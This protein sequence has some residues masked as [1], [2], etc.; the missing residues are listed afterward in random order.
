ML[1]IASDQPTLLPWAGF[2]QKALSVDILIYSIGV[3]VSYGAKDHYHNRVKLA[4]SW[5]TLP[6]QGPT[7][8][9]PFKDVRF[10]PAGLVKIGKSLRTVFGK[11]FPHRDRA[12][13]IIDL[14]EGWKGENLLADLNE[15][16]IREMKRQLGVVSYYTTRDE[17]IP[18]Q[19]QSKTERLI[20]RIRRVTEGK[21]EY[22]M[23]RG[24]LQY[25]DAKLMNKAGIKVFLQTF[26]EGIRDETSV[27][28]IACEDDPKAAIAALGRWEELT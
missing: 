15:H 28:L 7:D 2:F 1:K 26:A 17:A 22:Y 5:L 24:A 12:R 14:V 16:L 23:G 18:D 6:L 10:D 19:E 4:G 25:I 27:H 13:W 3:P 21:C 20:A 9:V 8:G 11:R